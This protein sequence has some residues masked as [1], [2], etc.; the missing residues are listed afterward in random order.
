MSKKVIFHL[1]GM[2]S[3]KY[4]GLESY[5]V[6]LVRFCNKKGYRS[7]FQYDSLPQS[8][9]YLLHLEKLRAK[10][11]VFDTHRNLPQVLYKIA[12]LIHSVSPKVVQT[13][14][15]GNRLRLFVSIIARFWRAP[16][17][18]AMIH[19]DVNLKKNTL[20]RLAFNNFHHVLPV[21]G[22]VA[23]NLI[24]GGV[25]PKIISKHYLGLFGER[26]PSKKVRFQL[27]RE[28]GISDD[29]V[30]IG[31]IAFDTPFK[32]LDILLSAL[33]K[34]VQKYSSIHLILVGVDPHNSALP[35]QAARLGLLNNVHWAGIRDKGW[36]ILNAVDVYV[37]PSRFLEGLSLA[38]MEAMALKLPVIATRVA[39]Q[40]EAVLEG[41]TGFLAE[42][43]NVDSLAKTLKRFLE[44]QENW[45]SMG[46]AG[47]ERYL[48]IFK[49]ENSIKT[50]VESYFEE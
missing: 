6:E 5:F 45:K 29:A 44:E 19:S 18:I 24:Q 49:G 36:Q 2:K 17:I 41:K 14:F 9:D 16:K 30:V 10:V 7:I 40:H 42:P 12:S 48:R 4:G 50:L 1:T 8:S 26:Q 11:V 22:A 33:S 27:R 31:C 38:I 46:E 39:G 23:Q 20:K 47:Y 3:T 34:I 21:S 13:H 43:D 25:N 32:G 15:I 37:Q 35:D 28:F